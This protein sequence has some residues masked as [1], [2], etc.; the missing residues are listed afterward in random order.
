MPIYIYLYLYLYLESSHNEVV[1]LI[2]FRGLKQ[3]IQL[4]GI[5]MAERGG[6][7]RKEHPVVWI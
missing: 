7:S 5:Q 3:L 2:I 1:S 6:V 4:L